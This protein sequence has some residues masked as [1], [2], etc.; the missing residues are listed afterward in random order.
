MHEYA[1]PRSS[2]NDP[3]QS[4]S[5]DPSKTHPSH[6]R[7]SWTANL[8]HRAATHG[9]SVLAPIE[10]LSLQRTLG[11]QRVSEL[12][13][14][15]S[16][17][18][19]TEKQTVQPGIAGPGRAL[20]PPIRAEMESRFGRDFSRIR[21]HAEAEA[22]TSAHALDA[23]AYTV[24]QDIVFRAGQYAPHT[25]RGRRLLAHELAHTLQQRPIVGLAGE[26]L[27]A[28][29]PGDRLEQEAEVAAQSALSGS[30]SP[31]RPTPVGRLV[32]RQ[33]AEQTQAVAVDYDAFTLPDGAMK[34]GDSAHRLTQNS[35]QLEQ[36][37]ADADR[38]NTRAQRFIRDLEE[39]YA[40]TGAAV[41][42]KE[43]S[44]LC[45]VPVIHEVGSCIPNWSFIDYLQK[46]KPGGQRLRRAL[47]NAYARR[48]KELRVRNEI[49]Q[50]A[51]N[52]LYAGMVVRG[53]VLPKSVGTAAEAPAAGKAVGGSAEA[54][55]AG[56]AVGGSAEAPAAGKAVGAPTKST[57]P[58]EGEQQ[59]SQATRDPASSGAQRPPSQSTVGK[60]AKAW[61]AWPRTNTAVGRL[62]RFS[63][64][65]LAFVKDA[66][67]K[68]GF[69]E[70]SPNEWAH[71]DGS[72]VRIDPPHA[73]SGAY[74]AEKPGEKPYYSGPPTETPDK[75]YRSHEEPHY[76]KEWRHPTTNDLYHLDDAGYINPD[77]GQIHIIGR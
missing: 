19:S 20:E 40:A 70:V 25:E 22:D 47:G 3:S 61:G 15:P 32:Q 63:G 28:G 6:L 11:N 58:A 18:A 51:L 75:P 41:A 30:A 8:V 68:A 38:G 50:H 34:S 73:P 69:R 31:F 64:R 33:Q 26:A 65:K 48:S 72:Y 14:K 55:A 24:G 42:D 4:K 37:Y 74:R 17:A 7:D 2:R 39:V 67:R 13:R 27:Q 54:P 10:V 53:G 45:Q 76:H 35:A 44:L 12:L 1:G 46:D 71:P 5:I 56:K 57:I 49:I 23:Q 59:T 9:L 29:R 62:P 43:Y 36:V 16:L 66:L 77:P 60:G 52:L 21:I